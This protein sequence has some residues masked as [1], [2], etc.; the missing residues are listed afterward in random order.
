MRTVGWALLA[1]LI[2]TGWGC[3]SAT[4]PVN[5]GD[6][7]P[8]ET[9]GTP[10][11]G[12][13]ATPTPVVTPASSCVSNFDWVLGDFGSDWMHPGVDCVDCHASNGGPDLWVGG[14]V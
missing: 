7:T 13:T 4:S 10:T 14:T 11:P 6:P 1:V 8:S 2:A 9:E 3:G 5:D 12:E